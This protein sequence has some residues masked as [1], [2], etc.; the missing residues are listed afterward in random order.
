[1]VP[2]SQAAK[3]ASGRACAIRV[4]GGGCYATVSAAINAL[5]A[6][7]GS[8]FISA[9]TYACPGDIIAKTNIQLIGQTFDPPAATS[10]SIN[11]SWL[12]YPDTKVVFQCTSTWTIDSSNGL[13]FQGIQIQTMS[14]QL[15]DGVLLEGVTNSRFESFSIVG[16]GSGQTGIGLHIIGRGSRGTNSSRNTFQDFLIAGFNSGAIALNGSSSSTNC[17]TAN[18]F[19]DAWLTSGALPTGPA[20]G[21]GHCADSNYWY[22]ITAT[23]LG[24]SQS[25][26]VVNDTGNSNTDEDS[27]GNGFFGI[28]VQPATPSRYTGPLFQFNQSQ[29]TL[30][31]GASITGELAGNIDREIV[32]TGGSPQ[33]RVCFAANFSMP[34]YSSS[35][36]DQVSYVGLNAAF[37]MSTGI[38]PTTLYSI[39]LGAPGFYRVYGEMWTT[40]LGNGEVTFTVS[41]NIGGYTADQNTPA[42]SLAS[43]KAVSFSFDVFAAGGTNITYQTSYRPSGSYGLRIRITYEPQ[44]N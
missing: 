5:P 35:C 15:G 40:A 34:S 30:V 14:P 36:I 25:A 19:R 2:P 29:G 33:F 3:A 28:T 24:D 44:G 37:G 31:D 41:S 18:E 23:N 22:N 42:L 1:M 32:G 10:H 16:R 11:S 4:D 6:S 17:V 20:I 38:D 43:R 9:G 7:G 27:G 8:V 13:V 26:L 21:L 12:S 39:P